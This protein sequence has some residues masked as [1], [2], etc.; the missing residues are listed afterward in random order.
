M[1]YI[2]I[3]IAIPL[4]WGLYKGFSKGLILEAASL[5]ALGLAIWGGIKFSDFLSEWLK[6]NMEWT[7]RYL[8]V[9]SFAIIFI[10]I[11]VLVF[12]MAKLLEK[13]VKAVSLG[14][15]NKLSGAAFGILKFGLILS[16]LIFVLNAIEKSIPLIPAGAKDASLLYGPVGKIAPIIIPGL[17]ESKINGMVLKG[18]SAHLPH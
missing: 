13:V 17:N 4:L 9:I 12:A 14:F 10:G 16:V 11:L 3:I 18:D 6:N 5:I 1:N 2:D 7:S 15:L 8:P